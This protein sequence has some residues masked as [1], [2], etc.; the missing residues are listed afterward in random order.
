MGRSGG[1]RSLRE[2]TPSNRRAGAERPAAITERVGRTERQAP[3]L[4]ARYWL[5]TN[6]VAGS[7]EHITELLRYW[8][9]DARQCEV[10]VIW[11]SRAMPCACGM[12]PLRALLRLPLT[13][14]CRRSAVP[15]ALIL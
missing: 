10:L 5:C 12:A 6:V 15:R 11:L 1:E 7:Q 2:P 9:C 8:L 4:K 3:P 14:S 13:N